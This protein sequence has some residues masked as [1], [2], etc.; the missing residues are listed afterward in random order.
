[1]VSEKAHQTCEL[2]QPEESGREILCGLTAAW[3]S[4]GGWLL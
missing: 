4:A 3:R 1:M 2:S